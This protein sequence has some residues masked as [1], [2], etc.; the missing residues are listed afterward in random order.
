MKNPTAVTCEPPTLVG[1]T[2]IKPQRGVG[3]FVGDPGMGMDGTWTLR[4]TCSSKNHAWKVSLGDSR[5]R[6][7]M[8][9]EFYC[10]GL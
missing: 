1:P 7:S 8:T 6:A 10:S 9:L 4:H 3:D 5:H 2:Q